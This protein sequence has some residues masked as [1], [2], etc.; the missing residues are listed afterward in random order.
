MNYLC[1]GAKVFIKNFPN[2][3]EMKQKDEPLEFRQRRKS[4]KDTKNLPILDPLLINSFWKKYTGLLNI[5]THFRGR[6]P[7]NYK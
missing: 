2:H 3:W 1:K 6:G 4:C 7:R 5:I